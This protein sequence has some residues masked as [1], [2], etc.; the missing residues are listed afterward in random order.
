MSK[1]KNIILILAIIVVLLIITIISIIYLN[2]GE[3]IYNIDESGSEEELYNID[4]SIKYVTSRNDYYAVQT[5]VNKYYIYYMSI[6]DNEDYNEEIDIEDQELT[7]EQNKKYLYNMLDEEYINFKNITLDNIDTKLESINESNININKMYV[8][9]KDVNMYIYLVQGRIRDVDSGNI[10][11][12]EVLLKLDALNKTFSIYLEDYIEENLKD[13]KLG[14]E[15]NIQISDSIQNKESNIYDYKIINDETYIQD[16][17]SKYKKELLYDKELAYIHLNQEYREKRFGDFSTFETYAKNNIKN[18][19]LMKISKYQKTNYDDYTEYVFIDQNGNYYIFNEK[20][21]MNF[22][23]ILDTYT[24]TLPEYIKKYDNGTDQ[25][26]VGMNIERVITAIEAEDY[27]Y[28]YNKLD[29][30]FKNNYFN[31]IEKFTIFIKNNFYEENTIEYLEFK[32]VGGIYTYSLNIMDSN[33]LEKTNNITFIIKLI[34]D[35]DFIM[36]FGIE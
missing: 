34:E 22:D 19:I 23:V 35:R 16:L 21:V 32:N 18:N 4:T 5:C 17:F 30:T 25:T 27:K 7:K 20:S 1:L 26:K 29:E 14:G 9:Q 28:V 8:S 6:F 10:K 15:I 2:R 12:F 3:V 31:T 11:D 13:L 33:N 36:S 24:I